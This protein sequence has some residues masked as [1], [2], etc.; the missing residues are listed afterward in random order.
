[1]NKKIG[2]QGKQSDER[3]WHEVMINIPVILF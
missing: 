1:M 2:K 3:D